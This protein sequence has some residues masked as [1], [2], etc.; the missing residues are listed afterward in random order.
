MGREF[1]LL[2]VVN[3][4]S[5]ARRGGCYTTLD[6]PTLPLDA[7]TPTADVPNLE[8]EAK[9][10]TPRMKVPQVMADARRHTADV[11]TCH[12]WKGRPKRR[13]QP[14]IKVRL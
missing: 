2:S 10:K 14:R 11:R 12:T 7:G 4:Q 1:A 5:E 3:C 6:D 13:R 9:E 8:R